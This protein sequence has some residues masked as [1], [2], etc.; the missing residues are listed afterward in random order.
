LKEF[1]DAMDQWCYIELMT[2]QAPK[3]DPRAL[4]VI[5]GFLNGARLKKF[6]DSIEVLQD[7]LQQGAWIKRGSVKASSGFYQGLVPKLE[8]SQDFTARGKEAV[9]QEEASSLYFCVRWGQVFQGKNLQAALKILRLRANP[10]SGKPL[11]ADDA[12]VK[13]WVQLCAEK[14]AAVKF[15]DSARPAPVITAIGLSP[16]VTATLKEMNLDID[17]PSIKMAKLERRERP[18]LDQTGKPMVGRD[19]EPLMHIYY[20]IVWSPGIAHNQSR[21]AHHDCQACGKTIPSRRFVPLE[22]QDKKSGKLVSLL[23]GC[24][25]AKNIFGVKDVGIEIPRAGKGE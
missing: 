19:G 11:G 3:I 23:V 17:L 24:D 22:A 21:F 20:V 5:L 15:L 9:L 13:A 25:C 8:F 7:S 1:L 12:A 14:S 18:L 16:K 6:S 4:A 10:Q 2:N